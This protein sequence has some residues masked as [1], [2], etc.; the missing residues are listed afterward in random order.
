MNTSLAGSLSTTEAP[1][2]SRGFIP[3]IGANSGA[4]GQDNYAGLVDDLAIYNR[5]LSPQE[6]SA[7]YESFSTGI[8][9]LPT[10]TIA[11]PTNQTYSIQFVDSLS[12]TNWT[13]LVS[14]IVL[15]A[16]PYVYPDTN[17][18]GQPERFYRVVAQGL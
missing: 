2:Y 11:G 18:V 15:Q 16:S 1:D 8:I 17:S 3:T 6:I 12:S 10:I 5:A 13:T 9:S 14:N 7:L 4:L